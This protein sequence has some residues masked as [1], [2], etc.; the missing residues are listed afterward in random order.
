VVLEGKG[1]AMPAWRD[2]I[3]EDDLKLLWAYVRSGG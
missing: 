3:S 2:K 1:Q